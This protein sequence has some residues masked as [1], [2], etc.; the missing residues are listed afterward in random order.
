MSSDSSIREAV[1]KLRSVMA[2]AEKNHSDYPEIVAAEEEVLA[3]YQPVFAPESIPS[4]TE[5]EFTDFLRFEN[6]RHWWFPP[7]HVPHICEDMDL[8]RQALAII[9][10]EDRPIKERLDQL[11]PKGDS[12]MVPYLGRAIITAIL[13]I[14]QP[15]ECGVWNSTSEN[16]LKAL[17]VFP[18]FERGA[19]FSERYVAFNE[20]LRQLAE[21]V[22][23]NLWN[24][25][26]LCYA[27]I[28]YEAKQVPDTEPKSVDKP[29]TE[30]ARFELERHLHAFMHD[31][32]NRISL[33][34]EWSL[35]E[36]DG[37]VVG[38][39]YNT[40]E[41]GS[42][43]LLAKHKS[44]PRWLVIELKRDQSSDATV[45]QVLRYMGWVEERL[46]EPGETVE[47][48]IISHSSDERIRYAL[49]HTS[50]VGVKLYEVDFELRDPD[51]TG[52]PEPR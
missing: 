13:L 35:Y 29:E 40:N 22:G 25:D 5:D 30:K 18:E 26:A 31:N 7:F 50:N 51:N 41:V 3:R 23:I 9:V 49:K 4:L 45:G 39:E 43:D 21:G 14:T 2:W 44:D 34:Q 32:W 28:T 12:P 42:I 6:N 8:L 38:F 20:V 16:A 17:D 33:G 24:L 47:G 46:A 11:L 52:E 36:E 37:E 48:L 1:G 10:D 19:P 15:E 27:V